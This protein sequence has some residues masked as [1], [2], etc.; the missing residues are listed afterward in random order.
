M[1]LLSSSQSAIAPLFPFGPCCID[2]GPGSQR[3]V[4]I[5]APP[6][7]AKLDA[8]APWYRWRMR[9]HGSLL[10]GRPRPGDSKSVGLE[11]AIESIVDYIN[12][13]NL[14]DIVLLGH[15]YLP[16]SSPDFLDSLSTIV[17]LVGR[18]FDHDPDRRWLLTGRNTRTLPSFPMAPIGASS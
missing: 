9:G 14:R 17:H 2:L 16:L 7:R 5:A 18:K 8:F 13:N 15:S 6:F 3:D 10:G 1:A 11:E 4:L 12:E